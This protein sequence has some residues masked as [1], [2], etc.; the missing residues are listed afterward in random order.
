[1]KIERLTV[2]GA[3]DEQAIVLPVD[4]SPLRR[5]TTLAR[6]PRQIPCPFL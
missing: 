5:A 4:T 3:R 6:R 1:M 2:A